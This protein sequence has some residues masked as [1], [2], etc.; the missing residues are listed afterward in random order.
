MTRCR[1]RKCLVS[2]PRDDRPVLPYQSASSDSPATWRFPWGLLS[3]ALGI[4]AAVGVPVIDFITKVP[5]Y[6]QSPILITGEV[7]SVLA[8]GAGVGAVFLRTE[9]TRGIIGACLGLVA[10]VLLPTLGRA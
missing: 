10:F 1:V 2:M 3:L 6:L 5:G 9:R 8:V 4:F 7:A